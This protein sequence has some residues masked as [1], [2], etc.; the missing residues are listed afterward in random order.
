MKPL[1]KLPNGVRRDTANTVCEIPKY[2]MLNENAKMLFDTKKEVVTFDYID[3][4]DCM[5]VTDSINRVAY[6]N[7]D[8][9]FHVHNNSKC[10]YLVEDVNKLDLIGTDGDKIIVCAPYTNESV[11]M[12][13][14]ES[15]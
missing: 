4:V 8:L 12:Y 1:S 5:K 7:L 11:E 15:E 6:F 13:L 14:K 3:A 9:F 2:D 10:M